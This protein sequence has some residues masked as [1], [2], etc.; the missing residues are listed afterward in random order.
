MSSS[1]RTKEQNIPKLAISFYTICIVRTF[2]V[3]SP[4]GW[5]CCFSFVIFLRLLFYIVRPRAGG[6]YSCYSCDSRTSR[7]RGGGVFSRTEPRELNCC[8]DAGVLGVTRQICRGYDRLRILGGKSPRSKQT[9][10]AILS[11]DYPNSIRDNEQRK[12]TLAGRKAIYPSA[13]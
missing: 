11:L 8:G 7:T 6:C 10:E 9:A 2:I 12:D 1:F 5:L 3:P 4:F 13:I